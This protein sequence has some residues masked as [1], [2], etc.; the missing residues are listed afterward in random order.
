[1]VLIARFPSPPSIV[2]A[3]VVTATVLVS[4]ACL[5]SIPSLTPPASATEKATTTTGGTRI[6]KAIRGDLNG[7]LIFS[8]PVETQGEITVIPRVVARLDHLKVDLGSRVRVGEVLAELDRT[9]LEQAVLAAQAAQAS[10]DATLAQLKAGPKAEVLAA[11]QA[12]QRAAQAR[13]N[14]LEG[15]RSNADANAADGRVRDARAALE[16]AQAA[17]TPD[18][19]AV[20][21]ADAALAAARTRLS[22][23]QADPARANDKPALDSARQEV[24]RLEAA[25]NAARTP[26]GSQTAVESARRELQ[27]AQQVQ[28]MLRL[29]TT[30]FDLDQA[31]ALLDAANAQVNLANA[32]ASAEEIKAAETRAEEAYAQA[33]LARSRLTN[34]TI[35]APISGIVV[36]IKQSVGTTVSP[37]TALL[38][39]IPPDM[40]VRVQVDETQAS[41]IQ[42]GQSVNLSVESFPK[43]SFAGTVKAIAPVLDP[44]TRTMAVQI[45]VADPQAKLKAGMFA[46]LSISLGQRAGVLMVPRE[47]ILR[48]PPVDPTAAF[49]SVVYTVT[50]GRVHKQVVSLGT[51]DGKSV[52]I[53]QGLQDGVDLVLNPRPDFIEGELISAS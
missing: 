47:A 6:G 8:A 36:D 39:L 38:T 5:P 22:Q 43:E 31:R 24:T 29:S 45:V 52:E 17:L 7:T 32:P 51:T 3:A 11:A 18:A 50:A 49:Q 20:A 2:R 34:A 21:T 15:A 23:L 33:E 26:S 9:E 14:A 19:Q 4:S 27:D 28:M 16:S 40:Q 48:V 1:M 30:A 44:R 12:N 42:V 25:A 41:Q 53:V 13:V 35:T 37:A 10:A 46:Q